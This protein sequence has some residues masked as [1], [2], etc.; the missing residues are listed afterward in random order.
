MPA[1]RI[2]EAPQY[3]LASSEVDLR[4]RFN[5]TENLPPIDIFIWFPI[6]SSHTPLGS[7]F[8]GISKPARQVAK[9]IGKQMAIK[10]SGPTNQGNTESSS[11]A[12]NPKLHSHKIPPTPKAANNVT[13]RKILI[14]QGDWEAGMSLLALDLQDQGHQVEKIVFCAS[15]FIYRIRGVRTHT[16]RKPLEQFSQWLEDL[17][18]KESFDTLFLYNHYRPYNQSAWELAANLDLE[19]WVFEQGLI[20]PNC[21]MVFERKNAPLETISEAWAK[22]T[23]GKISPP[24]Q[25]PTPPE[26]RKVS[27]PKKL[28][29]FGTSF[30]FSRITSPLFPNFVDQRDMDL[31]HH[32]KHGI[33]HLWRFFERSGDNAYDALFSG[34]LSEKYYAVPL[35]VHSDTQIL[36]NSDFSTIEEFI[37]TVVDSFKTHAPPDTKIVFKVHPMDRGYKDYDDLIRGLNKSLGGNRILHVDRVHLP[38]MLEHSLGLVNINSSVGISALIHQKPVIALGKAAYDLDHLTFQ[39]ELDDFW[40]KASTPERHNITSFIQL[41]L[42][43]SQGRGTLSQRC[44]DVPGRTCI[45]WPKSFQKHFFKETKAEHATKPKNSGTR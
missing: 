26:L 11:Q 6:P 23:N 17:I 28:V 29:S 32:L 8:Q 24:P 4:D 34:K 7:Y 9:R 22:I 35:Q 12:I 38:T 31:W 16:F 21:V 33:L 45:R 36:R 10:I 2:T 15:D 39:G 37:V 44:F 41:L 30:V 14:I 40:T 13:K 43:T 27:T 18:A 19:C 25:S 42:Q 1:D 3:P 5:G 20:R